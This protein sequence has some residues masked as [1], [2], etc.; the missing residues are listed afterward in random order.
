MAPLSDSVITAVAQ[1]V[2]DAQSNGYRDPSHSD[3]DFEVSR[4]QLAAGD[5]KGQGQRVG[6]AKRVRAILSW[7]LEHSP[8]AGEA[9]V[10]ALISR[11]KGHGGFRPTSQNFVGVEAIQNA[12]DV[13]RTEGYLL[14]D[15]GELQPAVLENLAGIKLTQALQAYVRRAQRGVRDAALVTG[16]GKDLLE[17]T[18]AHVMKERYPDY[19]VPGN[20]PTLLGQAF[21]ELGLETTATKA[22][23]GESPQKEVERA[24]YALACSINHLRNKEGTGHGHPWLTSVTEAQAKRAVAMMGIIAETLLQA[25]QGFK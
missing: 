22:Q 6:K 23:P 20:F 18:A 10:A 2:D 12:I 13:F 5:P 16:T 1:L 24:M 9:F 3:I 11:V 17:A 7:A 14:S 8:E 25:H 19:H 15:D 4:W 21:I